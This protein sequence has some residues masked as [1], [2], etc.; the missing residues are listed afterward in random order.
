MWDL[1]PGLQDQDLSQ[2]Q[3]V[4]PLSHPGAPRGLSVLFTCVALW[5]TVGVQYIFV[6]EPMHGPTD[7]L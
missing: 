4:Q 3:E 6:K 7:L 1:I 5:H 2:R